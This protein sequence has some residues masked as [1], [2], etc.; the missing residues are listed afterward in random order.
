MN[1]RICKA[2]NKSRLSPDW[3]Y[4]SRNYRIFRSNISM[5]NRRIFV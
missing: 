3:I 5:E 2:I 1:N 4:V